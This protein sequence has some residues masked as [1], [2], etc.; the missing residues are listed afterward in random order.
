MILAA[1]LGREDGLETLGIE[2][3]EIDLM[4]VR[5]QGRDARIADC[6]V[7]TLFQRMA[8]EI[9]N[10]HAL[11]FSCLHRNIALHFARVQQAIG[12]DLGLETGLIG[13]H[14]LVA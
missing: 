7:E 1:H 5:A 9:E 10:S 4:P 12:V 6:R 11:R 3:A 14:A 13:I 8:I 2:V